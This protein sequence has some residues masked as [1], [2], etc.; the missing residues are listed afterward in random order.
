MCAGRKKWYD[1]TKC[2]K[3]LFNWDKLKL[4][5][6]AFHGSFSFFVKIKKCVTIHAKY[7]MINNWDYGLQQMR[8]NDSR[9]GIKKWYNDMHQNAF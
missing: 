8:H 1:T 3:M 7:D 2:I 9:D 4:H 5:I 6:F